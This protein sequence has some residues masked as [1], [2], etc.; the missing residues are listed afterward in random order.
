MSLR[1][2]GKALTTRAAADYLGVS[3][4][5]LVGLVDRGELPHHRVGSHR[6]I[7]MADL[8]AFAERRDVARR[9]ALDRLA[10]EVERHGLHNPR[11]NEDKEV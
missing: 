9:A 7:A 10:S 11:V 5:H 3:R 2:D 1:P 8:L 4:Q 6:R